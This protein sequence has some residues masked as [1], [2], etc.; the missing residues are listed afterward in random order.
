MRLCAQNLTLERGGKRLFTALH[1]E[2]QAGT[3]TRLTG[4][5]GSGKTSLLRSLAGLGDWQDGS[6]RL[7]GGHAEFSIGAQSHFIA[8]QEAVKLALTARENLEFWQGFLGGGD[9]QEALAAFALEPLADLPAAWASSGQK[10]RMALARLALAF[11]PIWLLDEPSVGLDTASQGRLAA[12]MKAHLAKGG[13]ILAATHVPLG[14]ETTH[15][16]K[17]GAA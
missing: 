9:V 14:L 15:E 13:I 8:H 2:L 11:R 1:F 7:A 5:N 10:R 4:P 3:L 16:I 6:L 17:L 12:L